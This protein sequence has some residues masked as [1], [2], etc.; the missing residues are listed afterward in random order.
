VI[1]GVVIEACYDGS[2]F[3]SRVFRRC[4]LSCVC[5][6][7]SSRVKTWAA[8]PISI[9][10]LAAFTR[11]VAGLATV[12]TFV[13]LVAFVF[14][15]FGK[16]LWLECL[17]ISIGGVDARVICVVAPH[18]RSL[19]LS[20]GTSSLNGTAPHLPLL[21]KQASVVYESGER[22]GCGGNSNEFVV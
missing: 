9:G 21:V 20:G 8:S 3:F 18:T 16:S 14:F 15:F 2:V 17:N 7:G 19:G 13:V 12:V 6:S 10:A 22:I 4:F 11:K 5:N 1:F